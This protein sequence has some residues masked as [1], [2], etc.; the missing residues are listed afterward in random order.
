MGTD[1]R[2]GVDAVDVR[3]DNHDAFRVEIVRHRVDVCE[4]R[5]RTDVSDGVGR[6]DEGNGV[7]T[8]VSP[9]PIPRAASAAWSAVVPFEVGTPWAQTR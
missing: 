6:R 3:G 7:V 2:D 4:Q 9:V 5:P 1:G 8:T